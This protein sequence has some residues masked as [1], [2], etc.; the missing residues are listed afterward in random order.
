MEHFLRNLC[1][2]KCLVFSLQSAELQVDLFIKLFKSVQN[3]SRAKFSIETI[4]TT[5]DYLSYLI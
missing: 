4:E 2:L 1:K 5:A 3:G